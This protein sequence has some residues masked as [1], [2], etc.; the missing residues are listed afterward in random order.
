MAARFEVVMLVDD[1]KIDA[2]LNK[3]VLEK[4]DFADTVLLYNSAQQALEYLSSLDEDLGDIIPSV[5]FVDMMMPGL[6]GFQF[7]QNFSGLSSSIQEKCKIV[8]MSGSMLSQDQKSQLSLSENV[9]SFIQKPL[10]KDTLNS[11]VV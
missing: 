3:K 2:V 1:N 10:M 6:N 9:I 5:V 11:I 7:V 4:D 8:F